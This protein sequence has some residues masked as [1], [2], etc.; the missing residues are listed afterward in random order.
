LKRLIAFL[1][2]LLFA[3]ALTGWAQDT[4]NLVGS[5]MDSTGA[6]IPGAKVTI[7]NPEKGF[8]REMTSNSAGQYAQ[9]A[10][11]IGNYV[12]TAEAAGFQ[13]LVR[14]G[15]TLT[16]GQI[17][18]VDMQLQVGQTTQEVTVTGNIP[19]VQTE[20]AAISDVVTGTQIQNLELNGRNFVTLATLVPGA[21]P[22]NGLDT[23]HVGVY[24]NNSISFNGGRTQYNNWEID[25]GNNT[26]RD[27]RELSIPTRTWTRSPSSVFRL[28]TMARTWASTRAPRLR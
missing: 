26:D 2:T 16:V 11:P 14:T 24:G 27:R 8:T 21:V 22:D 15:I 17:Q 10:I 18:R 12:I 19:K 7:S 9:S 4:A 13:K 3:T 23:S 25:G 5:V 20:T 6:V 28:R 1:S